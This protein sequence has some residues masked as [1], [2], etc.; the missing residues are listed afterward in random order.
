MELHKS[1]SHSFLGDWEIPETKIP[2][3]GTEY[4]K[5]PETGPKYP[6]Q[7]SK[8]FLDSVAR[9]RRRQKR[10][11]SSKVNSRSGLRWEF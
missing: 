10:I 4:Q 1:T 8:L 3:T 5:I 6:R 7:D 11:I 9:R 2:E